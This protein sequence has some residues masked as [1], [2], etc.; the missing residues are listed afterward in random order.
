M[1][2]NHVNNMIVLDR[3]LFCPVPKVACSNW[4]ITLRHT[5]GFPDD[6]ETIAHDRRRN[7]LTYLKDKNCL[8]RARLLY[9]DTIRAV[10]VRDP[11]TRVLSAYRSKIE[12]ATLDTVPDDGRHGY[13][14]QVLRACGG[15]PVSFDEFLAYVEATPDKDRNE[16]W[17]SQTR[18]AGLGRVKYT[19]IGRLENLAEDAGRLVDLA[20][21]A[22]FH[23][24]AVKTVPAT[25]SS[26]L[27]KLLLYYDDILAAQVQRIYHHDIWRLG[28][29]WRHWKP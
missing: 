11:W 12:G 16:H 10:F 27:D 21:L 6:D 19:F 15:G 7:G 5:L 22:P 8:D 2:G 13:R 29:R 28:Y 26:E 17:Q 20:G 14:R 18:I 24:G 9:G 23:L 3:L 25:N 1:W 4:K